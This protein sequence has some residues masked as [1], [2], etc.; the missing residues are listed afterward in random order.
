MKLA[1][2]IR[3]TL[4]LAFAMQA[5]VA[6]AVAATTRDAVRDADSRRE[7]TLLTARVKGALITDSVTRG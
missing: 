2:A 6:T 5:V 7:D 1:S 3:L 4:M